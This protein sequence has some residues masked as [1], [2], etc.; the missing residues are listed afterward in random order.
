MSQRHQQHEGQ[1][2]YSEAMEEARQESALEQVE[3]LREAWGAAAGREEGASEGESNLPAT[4]EVS[5]SEQI[6][7]QELAETKDQL[8][9]AVAETENLR[10]RAQREAEDAGKFAVS[11]FAREIVGVCENLYRAAEAIPQEARQEEGLFSTLAQGV[12]MTLREMLGVLERFGV[13]RIDPIGEKFDHA[14][15]QAVVQID[16][17]DAEPGTVLQVMQAGYTLHGR[18]LRPAMVGVARRAEAQAP[19]ASLDTEA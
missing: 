10:R 3:L 13:R 1:H 17:P 2:S 14:V 9:R 16:H 6:L 5:P 18:L 4:P 11:S 8:L 19:E 12:D 7:S 15:H